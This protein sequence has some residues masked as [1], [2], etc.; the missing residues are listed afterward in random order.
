[1]LG[2]INLLAAGQGPRGPGM[3]QSLS[4]PVPAGLGPL[5]PLQLL[6]FPACFPLPLA[7]ELPKLPHPSSLL[8]WAWNKAFFPALPFV[9]W[10][11]T[12][13]DL[14]EGQVPAGVSWVGQTPEPAG[15]CHTAHI[16]ASMF[17]APGCA[18]L[19]SHCVCLSW[20]S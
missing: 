12:F 6:W 9:P 20:H 16:G 4:L 7:M 10:G 13:Q 11:E 19:V 2:T 5:V 8:T 1:M 15:G 14:G 3:C 18:G 17:S